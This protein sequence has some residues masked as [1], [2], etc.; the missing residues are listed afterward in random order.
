MAFLPLVMHVLVFV[1]VVMFLLF[2][3]VDGLWDLSLSRAPPILTTL[4]P[5]DHT[6]PRVQLLHNEGSH[7]IRVDT[8]ALA[9]QP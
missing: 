9:R 4:V 3:D 5:L 8:L 2:C 1:R 7:H 6:R